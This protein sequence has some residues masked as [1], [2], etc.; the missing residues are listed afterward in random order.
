M[1]KVLLISVAAMAATS[2]FANI[3][4]PGAGFAV[5]DNDVVI[6][7]SS[8]IFVGTGIASVQS[9]SVTVKGNQ[10]NTS[11]PTG[12]KMTWMGDWTFSIVNPDNV[13]VF[14]FSRVGAT[15]AT[16]FGDS[17]DMAG[18]YTFVADG[19]GLDLW[20][21]AAAALSA[22]IVA[23]G[24]YNAGGF[25][26]TNAQTVS[27]YAGLATANSGNWTL[28]AFDRASGDFGDVESWSLNATPV[29]EPATMV[30]L[31]AAALAAAA[32]KRRK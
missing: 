5:P 12:T 23:P 15:S 6:G 25:N 30:V 31:G 26:G 16:S 11:D 13:E 21:A 4:G 8:S 1:K 29:P 20:A 24:T 3:Y 10:A 28:R 14:L 17:S 18:L 27:S 22:D 7:G 19:S 32:R 9:V 2:A